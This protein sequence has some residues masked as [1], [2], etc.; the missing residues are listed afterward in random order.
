MKKRI[1]LLT[2]SFLIFASCRLV[3]NG[4][5]IVETL[6][7]QTRQVRIA[8]TVY[9]GDYQTDK[10]GYVCIPSNEDAFI[11]YL[12]QNP[13][14]LEI[15][16]I[17]VK[18]SDDVGLNYLDSAVTEE[19]NRLTDRSNYCTPAEGK[20]IDVLLKSSYGIFSQNDYYELSKTGNHTVTINL[21]QNLLYRLEKT[22]PGIDFN[23]VLGLYVKGYEYDPLNKLFY[24]GAAETAEG[25]FY[26]NVEP[27]L[28]KIRINTPPPPVQGACVMVDTSDEQ[29]P[30]YVLCFNLP[31][32][33]FLNGGIHRDMQFGTDS[34][35]HTYS[36][37][38][39]KI[40]GLKSA[41]AKS[42]LS[43]DETWEDGIDIDI[44]PDEP[45]KE[46]DGG[47]FSSKLSGLKA[48]VNTAE[49]LYPINETSG[50]GLPAVTFNEWN[51]PVW[52][53]DDGHRMRDTINQPYKITLVDESG[54]TSVVELN[55]NYYQ[56]DVI[57]ARSGT[58]IYKEGAI[59]IRFPVDEEGNET[60]GY[61]LLNLKAPGKIS[62]SENIFVK[63]VYVYYEIFS[64]NILYDPHD[65]ISLFTESGTY[66]SNHE[67]NEKL[68]TLKNN[69][70][71]KINAYAR[72]PGYLDSR[73]SSWYVTS[74]NWDYV[75]LNIENATTYTPEV[76][77]DRWDTTMNEYNIKVILE[78]DPLLDGEGNVV[79]DAGGNIKPDT[80]K[81]PNVIYD[82]F[83]VTMSV[84]VY[85][86]NL[87]EELYEKYKL[88]LNDA[89]AKEKAKEESKL[90]D[91]DKKKIINDMKLLIKDK[92]SDY[93]ILSYADNSKMK[94][95]DSYKL[96]VTSRPT[97]SQCDG[98]L[99]SNGTVMGDR[100][101]ELSICFSEQIAKAF[102]YAY[103]EG[104]QYFDVELA[105]QLDLGNGDYVTF[106]SP[107]NRINV[108]Y[109]TVVK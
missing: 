102:A 63:D 85:N 79:Y 56:L 61:Q 12:I 80:S 14:G 65:Q 1:L 5:N 11:K 54:L 20:A 81:E 15:S 13:E 17:G 55:A 27:Y 64:K 25:N 34:E 19:N 10:D 105:G 33:L 75:T 88:T 44:T 28:P 66:F 83:S 106:S 51:H 104:D 49:K 68:L 42:V 9:S 86:N 35:G 95:L 2:V 30:Y 41:I 70:L 58:K 89:L 103:E 7:Q 16:K 22:K 24:E 46:G 77:M 50:F 67:L 45:G 3:N 37:G 59:N 107:G 53:L 36:R 71:Y 29:N 97:D 73:V 8:K 21:N 92:E 40:E 76:R 52:I 94:I 43:A 101:T 62:G 69:T 23:S 32:S 109:V 98:Y 96:P 48:S 93:Q 18:V 91:E 31:D 87:Y 39:I 38:K 108:R 72:K 4:L 84:D 60:V 74:G 100:A 57:T 26:V 82:D 99:L 78:Y 6:E 90:S 47:S